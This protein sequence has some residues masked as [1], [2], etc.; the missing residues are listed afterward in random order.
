MSFFEEKG[1]SVGRLSTRLST[2]AAEVKGGTGEG[3]SLVFQSVAAV[4]AGIVIAFTADWQLALVV[5]AIMPLMIISF[6]LQTRAF[7]GYNL[8]AAKALEESGHI[9]HE[10]TAAIKTI[11]AFNMQQHMCAAFNKSLDAPQRAGV[12]KAWSAGLGQAFNQFIMFCGYSLA[13]YAGGQFIAQGWCTFAGL[14]RVYLAV[15][16][17]AQAAGNAISWG[18]DSAKADR[19]TRSIFALLDRVSQADGFSTAGAPL[20]PAAAATAVLELRGVS[21]AYPSRPEHLVLRDVS[22]TVRPGQKVAL[23]GP[24]GSGKS[25]VIQLLSRF[26]E[27]RAGQVLLGGAPLASYNLSQLRA[28]FGLI[29][30]EPSLFAD[31]ICYNIEYGR[32]GETKPAWDRGAPLEA[33]DDFVLPAAA[34]TAPPDVAAAAAAANAAGFISGFKFGY[35]THCGSRGNQQL[36]GGQRQRLCIARAMLRAPAI[37]MCDEAT[38]ALDSASERVVQQALDRIL[39][40]SAGKEAADEGAGA[41]RTSIVIAHRLSTIRDADVIYVLD[42][43]RVVEVGTHDSLFAKGGVY[44]ALATAQ[45]AGADGTT[46]S[47]TGAAADEAEPMLTPPGVAAST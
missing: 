5:T 20:T 4:V 27:P 46:V 38:S 41:G 30:Q 31:S 9:A 26:Y 11:T 6:I 8:G 10:A 28:Q 12:G 36:S 17:S 34:T 25:T 24:S 33:P 40:G 43:G 15:T 44:F 23:V 35:G 42:Q 47:P 21:F 16:L 1:N 32:V 22:L 19:G 29:Q 2:D 14:M 39:K 3:L 7:A 45:G 37:T 18:P 13:F